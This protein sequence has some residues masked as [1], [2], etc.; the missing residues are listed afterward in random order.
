MDDKKIKT[1]EQLYHW[2]FNEMKFQLVTNQSKALTVADF[3]KMCR[4]ELINMW[5]FL[6]NRVRSER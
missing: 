5:D 4:G 3:K 2:A 1:A 6:I